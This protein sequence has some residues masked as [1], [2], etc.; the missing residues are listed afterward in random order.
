MLSVLVDAYC[1]DFG[2]LPSSSHAAI[3]AALQGNNPRQAVYWD[4][5]S[6]QNASRIS[7]AGEYLDPWGTPY[8]FDIKDPVRPRVRSFGPNRKDDHATS[9]S[10]DIVDTM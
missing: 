3:L 4:S 10:D 7:P 8:Y 1:N 5:N 2:S 6:S 9:D